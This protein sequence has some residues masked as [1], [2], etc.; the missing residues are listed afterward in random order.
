V[1]KN[2]H[3]FQVGSKIGRA[4]HIP[5]SKSICHAVAMA[6]AIPEQMWRDVFGMGLEKEVDV[7]ASG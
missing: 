3:L 7:T 5:D 2:S 6:T 1:T 4:F